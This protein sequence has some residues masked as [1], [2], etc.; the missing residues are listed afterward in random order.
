MVAHLGRRKAERDFLN[1][2]DR[3]RC[4]NLEWFTS[5]YPEE[6]WEE[7][8]EITKKIAIDTAK[9]RFRRSSSLKSAK[10]EVDRMMNASIAK[11]RYY[12]SKPEELDQIRDHYLLIIKALQSSRI[13]VESA[14]FIWM[15]NA[16]DK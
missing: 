4:S 5:Q 16:N 11:T 12:G 2:K 14:A 10:R 7:Y 13:I 9:E 3:Y 6:I 8:V 1:Y 15:V